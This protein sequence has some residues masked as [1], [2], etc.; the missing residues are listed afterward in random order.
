MESLSRNLNADV[1]RF[2]A[3]GLISARSAQEIARL[4]TDVQTAFAISV[5]N[6]ILSKD[7]VMYLVNRYLNE[8]TDAEERARIV[9][10]PKMALPDERKQRARLSRDTSISARLARAVAGCLDRNA[11]L[12]NVLLRADIAEAAIRITD[13]KAL[14]DSLTTLREKLIDIFTPGENEGGD[15]NA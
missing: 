3:D 2:V 1:Q 4:P 13:I 8:D 12:T 5:S 7:N 6:E 14:I 9:S 15:A 11:Y 10:A